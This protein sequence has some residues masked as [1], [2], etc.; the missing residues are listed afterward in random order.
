MSVWKKILTPKKLKLKSIVFTN[1]LN[2]FTACQ[3]VC[4]FPF[5]HILTVQSIFTA[6]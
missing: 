3:N 1:E 6:N 4:I 5:I 2:S